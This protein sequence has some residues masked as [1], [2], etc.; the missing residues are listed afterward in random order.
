MKRVV[1]F[2]QSSGFRATFMIVAIAAAAWAVA[3]QWNEFVAGLAQLSWWQASLA[4][5]ASF[6]YVYMTMLSWRH[7]LNGMGHSVAP[8]PAATIFFVSQVAKYLPGGVWNFVA[9]AEA[10]VEQRISRRRS[11]TVLLTSMLVSILT[12]MVF[13]VLTL[14]VGPSGVRSDYG[15]T[16]AFLPVLIFLLI[17]PVLNRLISLA[18]R[19]LGREPL[20][21]P[22]G[23][24]PWAAAIAWSTAAWIVAGFQIWSMLTAMGMSATIST[25]LLA[26]GGYALAW[27]VGFL[28]FFVPAGIGVREVVLGAVLAAYLTQGSVLAVILLSRVLLTIGDLGWGIGASLVARR[29]QPETKTAI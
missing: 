28:V 29:Y 14:L 17:P 5:V 21:K 2:L 20:E 22:L 6:A 25:F 15:W 26:T 13:A 11:V 16:A 18:L 12:G 3:S 4:L 19:A 24:Q 10:G 1:S 23:W 8:G 7:L 9:A 27:T